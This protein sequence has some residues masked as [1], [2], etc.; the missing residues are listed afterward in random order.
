[1]QKELTP[2]L[3]VKNFHGNIA[4]KLNGFIYRGSSFHSS[5]AF[6]PDYHNHT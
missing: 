6:S 4:L 1:M 2:T 5:F 3:S